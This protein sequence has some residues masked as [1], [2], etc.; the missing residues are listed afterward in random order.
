MPA[1][2]A[3]TY[4]FRGRGSLYLA[5]SAT[6]KKLLPIGNVS[7]YEY[8][9]AEKSEQLLD[10]ENAGGGL[11]N[12]DS[13]IEAVNFKL[14][15]HTLKPANLAIAFRGGVTAV[16][17]AAVSAEVQTVYPGAFCL[18]TNLPDLSQTITLLRTSATARVNST[19]YAVGD[20]VLVGT[21]LYV[22]KTAGTS[23][24]SLPSFNTDGADTTDGGVTWADTGT[25]ATTITADYVL[26][27][28]GLITTKTG[29][30]KWSINGEPVTINYTKNPADI[31]EALTTS[32]LEYRLFFDG[33]N[34]AD[35]G[36]PVTILSYRTKFKPVS[37]L[38]LLQESGYAGLPMEGSVLQD[39]TVVGQGLSQYLKITQ[40][41]SA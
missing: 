30:F 12:E 38:G 14:T 25:T 21:H 15:V 9:V 5:L 27:R 10:Y 6:P 3:N 36:R 32:A 8:T 13:V 24:G 2:V 28:G 26:G 19:A 41:A 40:P 34:S 1:S 33:L 31:V 4:T 7:G 23:A 16:A 37:G 35:Q 20:I 29:K 18:F 11:A 22:C 17:S 39:T